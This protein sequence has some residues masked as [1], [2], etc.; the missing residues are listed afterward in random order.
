MHLDLK[1]TIRR[2][3]QIW[4]ETNNLYSQWAEQHGIT[5]NTLLVLYMV[6]NTER[7]T[8]TDLCRILMLPKQTV[9]S[10]LK[11]LESRGYV[12]QQTDSADRRSKIII[13]SPEGRDYAE[14]DPGRTL[15][16]RIG[17][18]QCHEPRRG[19]RIDQPQRRVPPAI[20]GKPPTNRRTPCRICICCC[21]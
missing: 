1:S 15:R 10:I 20:S 2:Y 4:L 17:S 5:I 9:N 19:Q 13:F 18:V 3:Y 6:R 14:H 8:Q 21:P 7:C 12:S 16:G 11:N